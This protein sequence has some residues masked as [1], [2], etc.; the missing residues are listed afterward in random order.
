MTNLSAVRARVSTKLRNRA[1]GLK[2]ANMAAFLIAILCRLTD[3][4]FA[5]IF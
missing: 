1:L 2:Q 3:A 5:D 4:M